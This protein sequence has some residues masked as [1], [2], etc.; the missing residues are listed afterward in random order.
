MRQ[1]IASIIYVAV[2]TLASVGCAT[3]P[4]PDPHQTDEIGIA[5]T[6][7]RLRFQREVG[8]HYNA[9]VQE[10]SFD[11]GT[12]LI[13]AFKLDNGNT[14]W[15]SH[16]WGVGTE[17]R[18]MTCYL[19]QVDGAD[20]NNIGFAHLPQNMDGLKTNVSP[21]FNA[22]YQAEHKTQGRIVRR[23]SETLVWTIDATEHRMVVEAGE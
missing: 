14:A 13:E 4:R 12:I 18:T 19:A 15:D 21:A 16:T 22:R 10:I 8:G 23:S 6:G 20:W 3:Q 7:V 2:S 9:M 17:K 1:Y 5:F 11:D